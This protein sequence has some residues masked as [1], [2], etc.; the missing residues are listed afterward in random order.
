MKKEFRDGQGNTLTG[1]KIPSVTCRFGI[2]EDQGSDT[3]YTT[4]DR[5]HTLEI[6]YN[7]GEETYKL[8]GIQTDQPRFTGLSVGSKYRVF[9][10][11]QEKKPI[12][13][14]GTS[15]HADQR[16]GFIVTYDQQ[17]KSYT[18]DQKGAADQVKIT[19]QYYTVLD[20]NEVN[21]GVWN[22]PTWIYCC[23]AGAAI[24]AL[25]WTI[26]IRIRRSG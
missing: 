10:L 21:T 22:G 14:S 12:I 8:D 5:L 20:E 6:T 25:I 26:Y 17:D 4:K 3:D 2:Y 15:Y 1:K 16:T 23:M 18:I 13:S 19:N 7:K 9:E 11:D 24:L